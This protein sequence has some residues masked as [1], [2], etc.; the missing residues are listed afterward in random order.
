[1]ITFDLRKFYLCGTQTAAP[2][3]ELEKSIILR[4]GK[5]NIYDHFHGLPCRSPVNWLGK[6]KLVTLQPGIYGIMTCRNQIPNVRRTTSIRKEWLMGFGRRA[7]W[8]DCSAMANAIAL[9]SVP[10]LK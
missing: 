3:L 2:Y 7:T 4:V 6:N 9:R 1:M 8:S 10:C 5:E